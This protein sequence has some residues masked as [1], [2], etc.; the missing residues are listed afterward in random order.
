MEVHHHPQVEKKNFKEYFLEFIMIFLAVTLGFFAENLRE[1]F[2]NREIEKNSIE[3]LVNN[4]QEDSLMLVKSAEFNETK[5]ND[6]DSLV[7]LKKRNVPD[8]IFRKGL[9]FYSIRLG[10]TYFFSSNESTFDEMKSSGSLRLIKKQDVVD[11]ILKYQTNNKPITYQETSC[12]MWW[13]RTEEKWTESTDFTALTDLSS[14]ILTFH[15]PNEIIAGQLPGVTK[16][17][18]LLQQYFNNIVAQRAS[19]TTYVYFLNRQLSFVRILI[20]YLE[21]EYGIR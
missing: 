18:I 9:T 4:L 20:T 16:D 15:T 8:T 7:A 3:R 2:T 6:I 13:N 1:Y 19:F 14:K 5:L 10:R 11:S 21:T 12:Q 17:S